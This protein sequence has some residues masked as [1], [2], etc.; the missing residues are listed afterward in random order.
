MRISDNTKLLTKAILVAGLVIGFIVEGLFTLASIITGLLRFP[1]DLNL[2]PLLRLSGGALFVTGLGLVLWLLRYRSPLTMI[3][4]TYFTFVKM[5][6]RSPVSELK[7]RTESL[8]VSGPQRYVRHPL[9]LGAIAV[10]LGLALLTGSTSSLVG[11]AFVLL[12]FRFVQIPF[13]EKELRAIF[14]EQYVHY[15]KQVPMLIP[16]VIPKSRRQGDPS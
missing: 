11:V 5:F 13:E 16:F 7:G 4:S 6:T 8:V 10:F 12:W 14:R 2:Q 15:S 1:S 3:M 9:Y